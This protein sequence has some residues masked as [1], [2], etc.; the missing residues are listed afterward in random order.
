MNE[1]IGDVL[2]SELMD[3]LIESILL[4]LRLKFLKRII[5]LPGAVSQ[6]PPIEY[7]VYILREAVNQ[8][9]DLGQRRA[10]FKDH[11]IL[12]HIIGE[13]L[14]QHPAYPKVFLYNSRVN[15][16]PNG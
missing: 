8:P 4:G 5:L 14:L 3:V 10:T 15:P 2:C 6:K 12:Q 7:Q 13:E 1:R 11:P 16:A 9:E